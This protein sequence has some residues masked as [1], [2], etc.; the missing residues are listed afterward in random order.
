MK[1]ILI[2]L[3]AITSSI[4]FNNEVADGVFI[5]DN[6]GTTKEIKGSKVHYGYYATKIFTSYWNQP[7][8]YFTDNPK[9]HDITSFKNLQ[10]KDSEFD[11]Y[12]MRNLMLIKLESIELGSTVI[13]QNDGGKWDKGIIYKQVEGEKWDLS[14]MIEKDTK[15][16]FVK[17][18]TLSSNL[19][20]GSVYCFWINKTYYM[21]RI[22]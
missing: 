14:D 21:F 22:V 12:T 3:V 18:I 17:E 1:T 19:E 16:A 15:S 2:F 9:I 13:H 11:A 6:N 7:K 20:K 4:T 8:R 10:L 5:T